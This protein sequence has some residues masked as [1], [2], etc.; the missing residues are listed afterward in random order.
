MQALRTTAGGTAAAAS[1]SR[2]APGRGAGMRTSATRRLHLRL[3]VGLFLLSPLIGEFLLGNTP[4]TQLPALPILATMY[5]GGAVLV[6]EIARRT[7]R[8]WP[9]IVLLAAAYGLLEEGPIDQLLFNPAY[10]GLDSFAGFAP[11]PGTGVSAL[12]LQGTLTLHTVWSIC[13]PIVIVETFS[14]DPTRPWLG[15]V[16]LVVT[17]AVFL[18]GSLFLAVFQAVELH[19]VAS[20]AQFVGSAVVI[21]VVI[22]LAFLVGRR[23]APRV[24]L[25]APSPWVVAGAA[26]AA[27]SSYWAPSVL[28]PDLSEWLTAGWWFVPVGASVMLCVRWS[29]R[30]GWGAAHR[31]ALAGGA[32]LTYVWAGFT[33]AR[34]LDDVSSS[35]AVLGNVVFGA[36]ALLLL[37]AAM[38]ALRGPRE[39]TVTV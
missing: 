26:F 37:V 11:I 1:T 14:R 3:V 10:L 33:Q 5:G 31:L 27:S 12:L 38:N 13:V 7:G 28:L 22:V 19:F 6:R 34:E 29:Q 2:A 15:N 9:T 35:V 36:S 25:A 16:G 23:P 17:G 18:A 30:T 20:P 32:L 4:I 8:G 21:A 24:D 39:E